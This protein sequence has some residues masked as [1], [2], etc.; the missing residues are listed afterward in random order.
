MLERPRGNEPAKRLVE[1]LRPQDFFAQQ[2]QA[3]GRFEISNRLTVFLD[4]RVGAR[5]QY[6]GAR[7]GDDRHDFVGGIA[8]ARRIFAVAFRRELAVVEIVGLV[9]V[10]K[11]VEAFVHPRIAP[12]VKADGH[13]KPA[14]PD[15]VHADPEKIFARVIDAVEGKPRIFHAARKSGHVHGR[16]P[17]IREPAF[18]ETLDRRLDVF[19]GARPAARARAFGRVERHR[20]RRL[21]VGQADAR[22]VPEKNRRRTERDITRVLHAEMP[23]RRRSAVALIATRARLANHHRGVA[24]AR[25]RDTL[26][27]FGG[28]H[29]GRVLQFAGTGHDETRGHRDP[30]IEGA[31]FQIKL[32]REIRQRV[33]AADVVIHAQPRVPLRDVVDTARLRIAPCR[34]TA[35]SAGNG[36][37]IADANLRDGAVR[38]KRPWQI[39]AQARIAL[40]RVQRDRVVLDLYGL[41]DET[42]ALTAAFMTVGVLA[43]AVRA[44]PVLIELQPQHIERVRT[45]VDVRD[46]FRRAQCRPGF[47]QRGA[48]RIVDAVL[49]IRGT[50][51]SIRRPVRIDR[52]RHIP[53]REGDGGI[54]VRG[55]HGRAP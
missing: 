32:L 28:E 52:L 31:V 3:F 48:D 41:D 1:P 10:D 38:C 47:I 8:T 37:V 49:P 35:P 5:Q 14:V 23:R 39:H 53:R 29:V 50:R 11:R 54:V 9:H 7:I 25:T 46:G 33:P 21:V 42:V 34:A 19:G 22:G 45:V 55:V 15:F 18:R 2:N 30:I 13:R 12:F 20:E 27:L 51:Q 6:R 16:R 36:E 24:G 43:A 26:L 4:D 40:D 17:R 44:I